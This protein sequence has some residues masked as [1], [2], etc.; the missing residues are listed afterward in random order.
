MD[1]SAALSYQ[2]NRDGVT[3]YQGD[4]LSF[5]EDNLTPGQQYNYV[6]TATGEDTLTSAPVNITLNTDDFPDGNDS[7][8]PPPAGLTAQVYSSSALELFWNRVP[9][10][11]LNYEIRQDGTPLGRTD[12]ISYFINSGLA[13]DGIYRFEVITIA[14]DNP[15]ISYSTPSSLTVSM[16]DGVQPENPAPSAP[17]NV[18]LTRYSSTAA[19]LF[20]DRPALTEQV[21]TTDV[22]RDGIYLGA[23]PGTSFYDDTRMEETR[24]VYELIAENQTGERSPATV[25]VDE[26]TATE[27]AFTVTEDNLEEVINNI[28]RI[29]GGSVYNDLVDKAIAINFTSISGLT[30]ESSTNNGNGS[31]QVSLYACEN[32]G[33]LEIQSPISSST[34]SQSIDINDCALGGET[35]NGLLSYE[36]SL[37]G[38]SLQMIAFARTYSN[39]NITTIDGELLEPGFSNIRSLAVERY[40]EQNADG[41]RRPVSDYRTVSIDTADR[42]R[43]GVYNALYSSWTA[44]GPFS[45]DLSIVAETLFEFDR[46]D[47]SSDLTR[48]SM[49]LVI[50]GVMTMTLNADNGDPDSFQFSIEQGGTTSAYTVAWTDDNRLR[51]RADLP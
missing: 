47:S 22:Y 37:F 13:A 3:V 1:D 33:S 46:P 50:E 36:S 39:G 9:N 25:L 31:N 32:G 14:Q 40:S 18:R 34:F 5:Y 42:S 10:Q 51:L 11:Q 16:K 19:E 26:N 27:P 15:G 30:L 49:E 7:T 12:G 4:G 17:Q 41:T 20:W 28:A 43:P 44:S 38:K 48:G 6:L 45:N 35:F 21:A 2:L 23:T 24:Y 29:T 8:V